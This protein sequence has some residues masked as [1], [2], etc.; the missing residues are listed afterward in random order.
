MS[1][2]TDQAE[3]S[4]SCAFSNNLDILRELPFFTGIPLDVMKVMAYL[5]STESFAAGDLICAQSENLDSCYFVKC[6]EIEIVRDIQGEE[7]PIGRHGEGF[8]F[9]GLAL[10]SP[11]APLFTVR[12]ATD[13]ECLTLSREKFSK[14]LERFPEIL[15]KILQ[16]VVSHIF[17]W[18]EKY[19]QKNGKTCAANGSME[20][21]LSLF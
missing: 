5:S 8:F 12:A 1:S 19:L 14:T 9:G 3:N 4:Q 18:E 13:V 7:I 2:S 6:G 10:L 20:L 15:P 11:S 21:G 16:S 17:K